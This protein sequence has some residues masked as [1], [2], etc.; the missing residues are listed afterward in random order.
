MGTHRVGSGLGVKL[1][2]WPFALCRLASAQPVGVFPGAD[3]QEA[4]P[5]S[6]GAYND[7]DVHLLGRLLATR[8]ARQPP[9]DLFQ[10]RIAEPIG[11]GR[12]DWGVSGTVDGMLHYNAAGTPALKG[13][14]GVRTTPRE[15]AR[16][17]LLYLNRGNW[18]GRQLLSAAFVD[19][20]ASTQVPAAMPG[21]SR[22]LLS[23]AYGFYW[24]ANGVM[25]TG[26]RRW[27]AAPP[28]TYAAHGASTNFCFVVPEWNRVIARTNGPGKGGSRNSPETSD[29]VWNGFL[30]RVGAAVGAAPA[31]APG[32]SRRTEVDIGGQEFR[33]NGRPT[34]AGRTWQGQR[35]EGLLFNAR[36]VQGIFDDLNPETRGQWAYPDT[37]VWDP[38]RNTREFV[39]AMPEWRR[40]GLL[41]F[42]LNLQGGSPQ[43]Y[44]RDQP[45]HNSAL[46]ETGGL[47]PDYL[48]RL[49]RILD[50][51]DELGMVV[52]LGVFYFGQGEGFDEGYQSLPVNWGIASG[53][54]RSFFGKL[55][56][57]TG[58]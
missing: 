54:K 10:R 19:E 58:E 46:T 25:A 22:S 44:S 3:W 15:L 6:Q 9:K 34:Y 48:A 7:H 29:E 52:I 27:P 53:R 55:K 32:R 42:T 36:L 56:E 23:G 43:G 24:W 12:W 41:A 38:E 5:E 11:M 30:A 28:K 17:G 49:E 18:N 20:A 45:W 35:I 47:R 51:A 37:G 2:V 1:I 50:R 8:L 39:A 26:R 14:G 21:R 13:N 40:H 33:I 16:L 31:R 57:I 4:S